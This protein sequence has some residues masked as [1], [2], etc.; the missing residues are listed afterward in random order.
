MIVIIIIIIITTIM[1]I[2]IEELKS[3]YLIIKAE[4]D[5]KEDER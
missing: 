1:I 4:T 5:C 2:V 3:G